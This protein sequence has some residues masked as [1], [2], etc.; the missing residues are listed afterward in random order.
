MFTCRY[1][2]NVPTC[3]S[4]YMMYHISYIFILYIYSFNYITYYI[5]MC[6]FDLMIIGIAIK[7]VLKNLM[8]S[9]AIL[10]FYLCKIS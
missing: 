1:F 9:I 8:T 3:I 5:K 6:T 7:N 4:M 2:D 10:L